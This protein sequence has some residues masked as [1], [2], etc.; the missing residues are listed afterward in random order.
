MHPAPSGR[1]CAFSIA[2]SP[3]RVRTTTVTLTGRR[4]GWFV[5]EGLV[6]DRISRDPA[7]LVAQMIGPH[8]RYPD[9]AVLFLGTMFA[10][11]EDRERRARAS[12]TRPAT[13]SPSPRRAWSLVNRIMPTD[14]ASPGHSGPAR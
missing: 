1:S 4:A 7:D 6:I 9:G 8:H 5:L 12:P 3:R 13:S 14:H 11:I 2:A 10:P